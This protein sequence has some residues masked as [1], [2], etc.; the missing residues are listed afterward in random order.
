M[1]HSLTS[2]I[3]TPR[4]TQTDDA[5]YTTVVPQMVQPRSLCAACASQT[6]DDVHAKCVESAYYAGR[7]CERELGKLLA[8][9]K[10]QLYFL[11]TVEDELASLTLANADQHRRIEE[12]QGSCEQHAQLLWRVGTLAAIRASEHDSDIWDDAWRL[13][14]YEG[15]ASLR[16]GF[17]RMT[18]HDPRAQPL[19]GRIPPSPQPSS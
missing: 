12:L 17:Q 11:M 14:R 9:L 1:P 6:D 7:E 16:E 18:V 3:C 10:S 19:H 13:Q 8:A 4:A 2:I 15:P 5:V